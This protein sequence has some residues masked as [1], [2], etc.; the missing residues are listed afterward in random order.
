MATIPDAILKSGTVGQH[1][2]IGNVEFVLTKRQQVSNAQLTLGAA[3]ADGN[4]ISLASLVTQF[5]PETRIPDNLSGLSLNKL[6]YEI[7]LPSGAFSLSGS[8]TVPWSLPF[9]GVS[10][11]AGNLSLDVSREVSGKDSLVRAAMT[12]T[13]NTDFQVFDGFVFCAGS[14]LTFAWNPPAED[15]QEAAPG[16]T[17]VMHTLLN[18]TVLETDLQFR[19]SIALTPETRVYTLEGT[20]VSDRKLLEFPEVGSLDASAITLTM[21]QMKNGEAPAEGEVQV[22]PRSQYT[23]AVS[24]DCDFA[25]EV[26]SSAFSQSGTLSIAREADS[27][28]FVYQAADSD[29]TIP[30]NIPQRETALHLGLNRILVQRERT[31]PQ[32]RAAWTFEAEPQVWF[33]DLPDWLSP[34]VPTVTG[35]FKASTEGVTVGVSRFFTEQPIPLGEIDFAGSH[36]PLGTLVLDASEF[37]LNI[38]STLDASM[39]L[40]MGIPEEINHITGADTN[41]F[42]TYEAGNEDSLVKFSVILDETSGLRFQPLTSPFGFVGDDPDMP[43]WSLADFGDFG[44][45]RFM[46]PAFGFDGASLNANIGFEQI[47]G[48]ELKIPLTPFKWLFNAAHLNGLADLMPDALP[49]EGPDLF[50]ENGHPNLETFIAKLERASGISL[51]GEIRDALE[52]LSSVL[53]S[54]PDALKQYLHFTLPSS[55][56]VDIAISDTGG[57]HVKFSTPDGQPVRLLT[58]AGAP[59]P[60]LL[61]IELHSFTLGEILTGALF[62]VAVDARVDIFDLV[63]LAASMVLDQAHIPYIASSDQLQRR[64]VLD[65]LYML[66]VYETGIPIPIPLFFDELALEYHGLENAIF[67]SHFK[68][69]MPKPNISEILSTVDQ[70][71]RFFTESD[72]FLKPEEPPKDLDLVFTIGANYLHLPDYLGGSQL[73][74]QNNREYSL[75]ENVARALN[76]AKSLSIDDIV[77]AIPLDIRRGNQAVNMYG[78]RLNTDWLLTTPREFSQGEYASLNLSA[79]DVDNVLAII[80]RSETGNIPGLLAF[81]RGGVSLGGAA[82]L[83]MMFGLGAT[84][85][86][87]RTAFRALGQIQDIFEVDWSGGFL[88]EP[89]NTPVILLTSSFDLALLGHRV[90]DGSVSISDQGLAVSGNLDLFPDGSP[91]D[92]FGQLT[93]RISSDEL[94]LDGSLRLTITDSFTLA[95]ARTIITGDGLTVD[96]ALLNQGV[97]LSLLRDGDVVVLHAGM[98]T[99]N[100]DGLFI[101]RGPQVYINTAHGLRIVGGVTVLGIG[102]NGELGY[103][104]DHFWIQIE[105][106]LFGLFEASVGLQ[107]RTMATSADI[108]VSAD[109]KSSFNHQLA[110]RVIDY[111]QDKKNSLNQ[112]FQDAQAEVERWKNALK[113]YDKQI[114]DTRADFKAKMDD[115]NRQIDDANRQLGQ[116]NADIERFNG[117]VEARRREIRDYNNGITQKLQSYIDA[118]NSAQAEVNRLAPIVKAKE[119]YVKKHPWDLKAAS[120]LAGLEIEF[121]GAQ[122]VLEAAKKS[123][124]AAKKSYTYLSEA[125][126]S[127]LKGFQA[128]LKAAQDGLNKT[129]G[130][131]NELNN[132]L[133]QLQQ[134]LDNALKRLGDLRQATDWSLNQANAFLDGLRQASGGLLDLLNQIADWSLGVL[135]DVSEAHFSGNLNIVNGGKVSLHVVMTVQGN[136]EDYVVD[137]NFYN[138]DDG[139]RSLAEK[140]MNGLLHPAMITV[141]A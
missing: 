110:Q 87:M 68:F 53:D 44:A 132:Q 102:V 111:M 23:W 99:I 45:F 70:F 136:R 9:A 74:D 131:V 140:V 91:V 54:L 13:T 16:N 138:F 117:Q 58:M 109:M 46:F 89:K 82:S 57:A 85:A 49:V 130:L 120:E 113:D 119:N 108:T 98:D 17:W 67:Q 92:L 5:A 26:L 64:I 61:G 105:G 73:G 39:N 19:S 43:G 97:H 22:N 95:S 127:I 139:A 118:V 56:Q 50:D 2:K 7:A 114:A 125:T 129:Q 86:G 137:F 76:A 38:G 116:Y 24:A 63:T 51:P 104:K 15:G 18:A 81:L 25:L 123:L 79:S 29:W 100:I 93:G 11:P 72:Y 121:H 122:G 34:I 141:P 59:L 48:R 37:V 40:G 30:L 10:L 55:F 134:G 94:Y 75:W 128:S 88:V 4:T 3:M 42:N 20:K 1:F 133:S 115:V 106:S 27:T 90:L 71:Q 65:N 96:V 103:V 112:A 66:I 41:F 33:T 12:T 126:D 84:A 107:S 124:E 101:M 28:Q 32:T 47:P 35:T 36:I 60:S 77:A 83:D 135:L 31:R 69:P 78:V 62:L 80:P 52:K 6:A 8:S 14:E 21:T